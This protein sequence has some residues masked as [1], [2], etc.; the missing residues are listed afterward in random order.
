MVDL[1]LLALPPSDKSLFPNGSIVY[2]G[3]CLH[4]DFKRKIDA[5]GACFE[6]FYREKILRRVVKQEEEES[7]Q[8]QDY[9]KEH[10]G[11][12]EKKRKRKT[13]SELLQ[14]HL[15]DDDLYGVLGLGE[16]GM[17]ST[18]QDIKTA[19][20][21]MALQYHPDK[22]DKQ[23]SGVTDPMWLKVQK[24]YETLTDPEKKKKYDSTTKFDDSLPEEPVNIDKFFDIFGPVFQ[25]NSVWS[26]KKNVPVIGS[27]NTP[28]KD[29][30]KFYDFWESF[31]SWRDF[32]VFDEYNLEEA[33]SRYEKRYME[34]ENRRIKS[35][36]HKKERQRIIKLSN[37]AKS[38]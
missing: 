22:Q 6:S 10:M 14:E 9:E 19:Y 7:K 1:R 20:R 23:T 17:G 34:R 2:S 36:H 13:E 31:E 16:L 3:F 18:M 5:A 11:D 24:A 38:W 30:F 8:E 37:M 26:V 33:E 12:W 25:R 35:T 32:S 4:D 28:L 27:L 21:K 29:V 15:E